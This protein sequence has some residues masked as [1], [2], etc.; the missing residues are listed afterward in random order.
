MSAE[1]VLP[2][3]IDA[4]SCVA[5][6]THMQKGLL[7]VYMYASCNDECIVAVATASGSSL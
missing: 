6:C 4:S 7:S 2:A 5:Q 3:V 1:P